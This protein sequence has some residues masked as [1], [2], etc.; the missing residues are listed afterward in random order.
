MIEVVNRH[1]GRKGVYIGRGTPLGNPYSHLPSAK[2]KRLVATRDEAV[3]R[4]ERWLRRKIAKGDPAVV[5]E[6]DR[7]RALWKRR[8]KLV[9]ECFCAPHRCHG[10]VVKKILEEGA[11]DVEEEEA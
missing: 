6:L 10:D 5:G 7:L 9:L 4:Y 2:A 11:P 3:D 1:H 8:G